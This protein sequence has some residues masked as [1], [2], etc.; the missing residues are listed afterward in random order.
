MHRIWIL[1]CLLILAACGGAQSTTSPTSAPPT[2]GV[3]TPTAESGGETELTRAD[4]LTVDVSAVDAGA[5]TATFT[6]KYAFTMTGPA[7]IT[8]LPAGYSLTL[9]GA[10]ATAGEMPDG[11]A[12]VIMFP[13]DITPGTYAI[14]LPFSEAQASGGLAAHY[15]NLDAADAGSLPTPESYGT[16]TSGRLTLESNRPFT[17]AFEVIFDAN[18]ETLNITG[19]FN[20]AMMM[21]S[22]A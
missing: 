10:S 3:P 9:A 1:I 15:T 4:A 17:G 7:V 2:A 12:L 20:Q 5:F 18:G 11:S 6:G 16:V 13:S 19:V 21:A 14:N 8:V 22:G